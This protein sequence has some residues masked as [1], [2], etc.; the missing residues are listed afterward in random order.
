MKHKQIIDKIGVGQLAQAIEEDLIRLINLTMSLKRGGS[1]KDIPS[2]V[3]PLLLTRWD[4][5]LLAEDGIAIH[6][7]EKVVL[8]LAT[9]LHK[10]GLS[11]KI[12]TDKAI[13]A[14]DHLNE[15][16]VLS[17]DFYRKSPQ[18]KDL[19]LTKP[20][21]WKRRPK[22]PKNTTFFRPNDIVSIKLDD[23]Y[24]VAYIHE[25]TGV[26]ESPILE[27]YDSVFENKP[28]IEDITALKAKGEKYN[29]GKVRIAHFAIYGMKYQ[30]DFANQVHLIRAGN[31]EMIPDNSHLE[32]A[33][34]L[35][36]V[37]DLFAIQKTIE[38]MFEER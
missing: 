26:N 38:K 24:Y 11:D 4:C 13:N 21:E 18:I 17:D 25:L 14:I 32:E 5:V 10:Y 9:L 7:K 34:G 29:D 15:A 37:S 20:L 16:V 31:L 30:P 23:K 19:L 1:I 27:F 35:F 6:Y 2:Y 8:T 12:I 33:I 22:I 36:T 28:A 3:L